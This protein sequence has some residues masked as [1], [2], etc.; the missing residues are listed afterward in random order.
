MPHPDRASLA[1]GRL[2]DLCDPE[3][4]GDEL[5]SAEQAAFD[6]A[7]ARAAWQCPRCGAD[8]WQTH[9]ADFL[10]ITPTHLL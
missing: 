3:S 8:P 10:D 5:T 4:F 9:C 6:A 2:S 1:T 7:E